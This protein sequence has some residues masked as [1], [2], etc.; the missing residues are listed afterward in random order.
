MR[1]NSFPIV[2]ASP[3]VR[4]SLLGLSPSIKYTIRVTAHN[5]VSEQ[6]AMGGNK[7]MCDLTWTT[8]DNRMSC[9]C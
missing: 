8:P 1:D 3:L 7:R 9:K 6:D 2:N 4:Y 5:G